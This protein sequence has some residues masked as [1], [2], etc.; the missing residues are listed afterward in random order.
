MRDKRTMDEGHPC[1]GLKCPS[2]DLVKAHI[3][4]RA[5]ARTI[6]GDGPN[7]MIAKKRGVLEANPQLGEYDDGILCA[8]CDGKLGILDDYAV[9]VCRSFETRK[10]TIGPDIFEMSGVDGDK[11]ATAI[12]AILWRASVSERDNFKSVSLGPYQ[13]TA[14]DV[15][16][17]ARELSAFP[18]YEL[19]MARYKKPVHHDIYSQPIRNRLPRNHYSFS[20]CGFGLIAK[21][22]AQRFSPKLSYFIVNGNNALRGQYADFE[23]TPDYRMVMEIMRGRKWSPKLGSI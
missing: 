6:K 16:F 11:F 19:I 13:T 5:F 8:S 15:V 9:G 22:A 14:R 20:L 4:P 23:D 12:L 7:V 3:M 21:I 2:T 17:G 18:E 10:Q 1:R